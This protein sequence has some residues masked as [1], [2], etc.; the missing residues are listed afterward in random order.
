MH[1]DKLRKR[2]ICSGY[3][4]FSSKMKITFLCLVSYFIKQNISEKMPPFV[5]LKS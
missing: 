1:R 5:P 3:I 2:K 4:H